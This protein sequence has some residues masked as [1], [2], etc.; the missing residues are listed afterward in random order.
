MDTVDETGYT[1]QIELPL[2]NPILEEVVYEIVT[3]N[4]CEIDLYKDNALT[5]DRYHWPRGSNLPSTEYILLGSI[6][7]ESWTGQLVRAACCAGVR[8]S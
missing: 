2:L 7:D 3:S 6:I 4:K 8:R 5:D 1:K